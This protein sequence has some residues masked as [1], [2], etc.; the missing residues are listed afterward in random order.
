MGGVL[1]QDCVILFDI[2]GFAYWKENP[3]TL[4]QSIMAKIG[5]NKQTQIL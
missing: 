3:V 1:K 4:V 2:N 5:L